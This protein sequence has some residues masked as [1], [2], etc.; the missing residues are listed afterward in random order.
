MIPERDQILEHLFTAVISDAL[1]AMGLRDQALSVNLPPRSGAPRLYGRCRT[2][3]WEDLFHE[4]PE[5]YALELEAVDGCQPGDV[6]IAAAGGSQRSGIWGE[7][8]STAAANR[9]CVGAL[10]DGAVRDVDKM[11]DMGFTVFA[12]GLN[13]RD[14]LHRQRVVAVDLPVEVGGVLIH[15]G[16]HLFAD[17]DG[18]V[19]I[20]R[21][22]TDRVLAAAWRK[23]H[24]ENAVRDDIR[25]GMSATEVFAKHGIL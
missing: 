4:D 25:A 11:R 9:G 23:V 13:P 24:A 18:A 22:E 3:L 5:P 15:T 20:P 6:L 21:A 8:L 19:V 16:D 2:T 1:D 12:A 17:E 10:V 14:S 7:L